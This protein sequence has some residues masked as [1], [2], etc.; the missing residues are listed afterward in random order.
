MTDNSNPT[1]PHENLKE[2]Y[3]DQ[4]QKKRFKI[5]SLNDAEDDHRKSLGGS[6]DAHGRPAQHRHVG[7][8][9]NQ[10]CSHHS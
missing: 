8:R 9:P 5:E 1:Q 10:E 2:A 3:Q 7:C 4:R 6:A